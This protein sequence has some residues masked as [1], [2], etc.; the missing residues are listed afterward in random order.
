MLYLLTAF[1]FSIRLRYQGTIWNDQL[2]LSRT[3]AHAIKQTSLTVFAALVTAQ[4]SADALREF[5][6]DEERLL[7]LQI[8]WVDFLVEHA[9]AELVSG[10]RKVPEAPAGSFEAKVSPTRLRECRSVVP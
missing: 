4:P 2:Q 3:A 5:L 10:S 9:T 6:G 7:S 8:S 1:F